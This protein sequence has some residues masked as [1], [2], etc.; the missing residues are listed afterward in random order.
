MHAEWTQKTPL[1]TSLEVIDLFGPN[2]Q[3]LNGINGIELIH[4]DMI[5]ILFIITNIC[6][7]VL[8]WAL[9]SQVFYHEHGFV[10]ACLPATP[11]T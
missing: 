7:S 1:G 5:S 10:F 11:L 8:E 4:F 9:V 3:C 2:E 6:V